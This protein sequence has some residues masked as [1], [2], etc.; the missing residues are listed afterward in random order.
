MDQ[1]IVRIAERGGSIIIPAFAVDRTEVILLQLNAL[2]E[3]G[4]IP[5]LPVFVDSPM[6]L[7]GLQ[8]YRRAIAEEWREIR[9]TWFGK[10]DPFSSNVLRESRT[11]EDSKAINDVQSRSSLLLRR[12]W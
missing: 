5:P 6:A 8:V 9:P 12:G 2:R 3:G 1:F 4:L 11:V 10:E 7:A